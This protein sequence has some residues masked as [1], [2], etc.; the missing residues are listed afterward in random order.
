M[1]NIKVLILDDDDELRYNL[2]L[3]LEDDGF[4]CKQAANS[5]AALNLLNNEEFS[6]AIV[7]I[8][9]PGISGDEFIPLASKIAPNLKYI[10]HTGSTDFELTSELLNC[11]LKS[12]DVLRK[13]ITDMTLFSHKINEFVNK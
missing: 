4:E 13:P 3:F 6:V 2:N 8:R 5:E 9:L 10:V 11:G 1:N 7:D 12:E